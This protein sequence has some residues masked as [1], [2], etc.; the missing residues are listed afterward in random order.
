M[1]GGE[2]EEPSAARTEEVFLLLLLFP[3][4]LFGW[5]ADKINW[6][7]AEME[8]EEEEDEGGEEEGLHGQ[9]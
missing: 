1:C 4:L 8:E 2:I 7:R 3:P 5:D 9:K 6:G